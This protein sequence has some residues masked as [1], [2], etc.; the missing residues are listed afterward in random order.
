M[1][2]N[3]VIWLLSLIYF[4]DCHQYPGNT[5][6][7]DQLALHQPVKEEHHQQPEAPATDSLAVD[8]AYLLGKFDP[9]THPDFTVIATEHTNKQGAYLRKDAYAAFVKMYEAARKDGINLKIISATRNFSSQKGIWEAK[10]TGERIV[11]GKNLATQVKDTVERA[12]IILHYSSMPGTSRH[13]WGTD[14]DINSLED[15]Y[16]LQGQGKKE[17]EWLVAHGPEYGFCQPYSVKG[18]KRPNGY[19]EEKWH[20][21]YLP[22]SSKLV[23][24][25]PTLVNYSMIRGFKG[26]GTASSLD[27]IRNY[28]QGIAPECQP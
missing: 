5:R 23:K 4:T 13:H 9:A 7:N 25:Y 19:E 27:V 1:R 16:F 10:W 14:I 12:R 18:E 28:V 22:V 15:G 17:Y 20:W 26:S 3:R 24:L 8:A 2:T 6:L 11:E 21:S